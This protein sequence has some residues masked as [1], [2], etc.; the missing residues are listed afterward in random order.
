MSL[1]V[2]GSILPHVLVDEV[3]LNT[4]NLYDE[5]VHMDIQYNDDGWTALLFIDFSLKKYIIFVAIIDPINN[6][7]MLNLFNSNIQT[8]I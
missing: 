4:S 7:S 1:W 5:E 6:M 8:Y 2:D 3:G